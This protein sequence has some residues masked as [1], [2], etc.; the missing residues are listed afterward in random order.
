MEFLMIFNFRLLQQRDLEW[1]R[2]L[3]NDP[4][5]LDNLTDPTIVS[6]EQ[7][8]KW[9]YKL[10]ESKT[11]ERWVVENEKQERIGLIRLDN[12]DLH[13][14]SICVGMDIEKNFRG[15]GLAKFIYKQLIDLLF[16]RYNRIWLLVAEYNKRAFHIYQQLGFEEEGRHRQ[17]L[18]KNGRYYD[19]ILMGLLKSEYHR[20]DLL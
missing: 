19:Y 10:N 18:F 14:Y 20:I 13:N 16:T 6:I 5:V 17:G 8:T 11:S 7:Q 1:A 15:K 4:E 12:I 9:W 2:C 3:H